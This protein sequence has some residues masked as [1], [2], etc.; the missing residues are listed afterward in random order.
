MTISAEECEDTIERDQARLWAKLQR[1]E[2]QF[3]TGSIAQRSRALDCIHADLV[4]NSAVG[5]FISSEHFPKLTDSVTIHGV[6]LW[7]KEQRRLEN[8]IFFTKLRAASRW[9]YAL[10]QE[11]GTL[12]RL[13]RVFCINEWMPV[14]ALSRTMTLPLPLVLVM[15]KARGLAI[16]SIEPFGFVAQDDGLAEYRHG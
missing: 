11:V 10:L 15:A 13:G 9:I 2:V 16:L 1:A 8:A 12:V 6:L 14:F 3:P 5:F 4:A 7:T